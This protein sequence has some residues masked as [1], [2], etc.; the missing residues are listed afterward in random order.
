VQLPSG[1]TRSFLEDEDEVTM[2]AWCEGEGA[3][4]IGF[5]DCVGRVVSTP[6]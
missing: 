2:K 3:V 4:R 6:L 5:G 1:E